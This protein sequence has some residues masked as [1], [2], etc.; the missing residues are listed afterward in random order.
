[1]PVLVLFFPLPA[2]RDGVAFFYCFQSS[3]NPL[4]VPEV[5]AEDSWR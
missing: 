4:V 3:L 1:M 2:S 5:S